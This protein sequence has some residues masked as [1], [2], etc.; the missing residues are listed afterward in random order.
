ME[1]HVAAYI[2][3]I[4]DGEGCFLI[5]KFATDRSPIGFQFRSSAQLTRCEYDVIKF[6]ADATGRHIQTKRLK[7]TRT[8]Y[9]LVWR[10][11]FAVEF[12]NEIMPYLIGKKSQAAILL[13]YEANI[14]PGRG[15]TYRPED[16]ARCEAARE[17]LVALRLPVAPRC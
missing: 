7:S 6:I 11:R 15:R 12:I 17:Q 2:A 5:E 13:D 9:V 1:T 4:M 3:G 16:L 14:A 8:A 10:N